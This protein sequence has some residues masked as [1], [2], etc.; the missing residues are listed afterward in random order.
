M[1]SV[2]KNPDDIPSILQSAQTEKAIAT[3]LEIGKFVGY[4]RLDILMHEEVLGK[5]LEIHYNKCAFCEVGISIQDSTAFITHYR[6][7]ELY[8]WLVYEWTNLL[9]VCEECKLYEDSQFPIM[10]KHKRVKKPPTD[11]MLWRAD[12]DI[13]LAE[14]PLIINPELDIPEK[15]IAIDRKGNLQPIKRNLRAASTITAYKINMGSSA[16]ARH[17]IIRDITQKFYRASEQL[18]EE[19]YRYP[20]PVTLLQ[21]YFEPVLTELNA[22]AAQ[23]TPHAMLGKNMIFNF[24]YFFIEECEDFEIM[25]LLEQV[26]VHF[27]ETITP[28]IPIDFPEE[29]RAVEDNTLILESMFI[30]NIRCFDKLSID[31]PH[32]HTKENITLIVGTNGTGKSTILQ[33][34]ALGLSNIPKPP[35][36]YGWENVVHGNKDAGHLVLRLQGFGEEVNVKFKIDKHGVMNTGSH[37]RYFEMIRENLLILGYSTGKRGLRNYDFQHRTFAPIASLFG[38]NGFLKSEDDH[39][40]YTFIENNIESIKKVVNRLLAPSKT[41][42]E[43]LQNQK[44][45]QQLLGLN[46]DGDFVF[47]TS[48][49]ESLISAMS[50]GFQTV[51]SWIL[52]LCVRAIQHPFD[53][54]KPESIQAIVLIDEIDVHLSP[55]LQRTLIPRLSE[56]FPNTQFIIG[57]QSPFMIQ[58]MSA[59][60]IISLEWED[61]RIIAHPLLMEGM[62]WAWTISEILARL[63]GNV[64]EISPIMDN[65]LTELSQAIGKDDKLYAEQLYLKIKNALPKLS[66]YHEYLEIIAKDFFSTTDEK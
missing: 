32:I 31:L 30:K 34:I 57:T 37:R 22:M 40:T 8:Y 28:F 59:N 13:H 54:E 42:L 26:Q 64:T 15:Y 24:E 52:D 38:E 33:L 63:L 61:E 27:I 46:K 58:S 29:Q 3:L 65:Y 56:V 7:P 4:P 43:N 44:I 60:N 21:K 2:R 10:N 20:A 6:S 17:R 49:G 18:L 14:D 36:N 16:V 66:P 39:S 25:R 19:T 41:A 48:S 45:E 1:I 11:R 23:R 9:P 62:P 35:I 47:Q 50:D 12:S 51:F 53:L 55:N 5:L